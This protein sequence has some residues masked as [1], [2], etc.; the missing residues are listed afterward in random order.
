MTLRFGAFGVRSIEGQLSRL[1]VLTR[2]C[3]TPVTVLYGYF[4]G[5]YKLK[6]LPKKSLTR[7]TQGQVARSSIRQ[8]ARWV[9]IDFSTISASSP[10]SSVCVD[11]LGSGLIVRVRFRVA[12]HQACLTFDYDFH[13][14][15]GFVRLAQRI[16]LLL[17]SRT[18]SHPNPLCTG[19]DPSMSVPQIGY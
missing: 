14:F 4:I 1:A 18:H 3:L 11:C 15:D 16:I 13:P 6:C 19:T 2:A 9:R 12:D 8:R 17:R 5:Y 7:V 10:P